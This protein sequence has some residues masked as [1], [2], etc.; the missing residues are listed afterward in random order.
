MFLAR[1]LRRCRSVHPNSLREAPLALQEMYRGKK[2]EKGEPIVLQTLDESAQISPNISLTGRQMWNSTKLIRENRN[3]RQTHSACVVGGSDAI[4]CIWRKYKIVPNVVYVPDTEPSVPAWCLEEDLPTCIV[5]C[6]PVEINRKLL[7]AERADGYA[8]EFSIPPFPILENYLGEKKFTRLSSMLVLIGLRIPSNVGLLIKAAVDMGFESILLNDCVDLYNEKVLR[9]SG[10]AVFSP[11]IKL[12]ETHSVS[13]SVLSDIAMDHKLLPL[14][15]VPSQNAESAFTVAKRLHSLNEAKKNH[16]EGE[17]I[18]D[19]CG[20]MLILGSESQGLRSLAGE[21]SIPHQFVS[22]PLPNPSVGSINVGVAGSVLLH[23]FRP[24]AE[25]H[26]AQLAQKDRI[27]L[28]DEEER[29][30]TREEEEE[31]GATKSF[32]Q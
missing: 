30:T 22:V 20:P 24:A 25:A 31:A 2:S 27:L 32:P 15:A 12:F 8:A 28:E 5:R 14:L 23:A 11:K 21:W 7:S 6:S 1:V 26:F 19:H 10:G 29:R 9:A 3:F 16:E 17:E 4:K 18:K 13:I